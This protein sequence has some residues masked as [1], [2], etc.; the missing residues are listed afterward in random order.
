MK[1]LTV[2]EILKSQTTH[3]AIR[4]Q[5]TRVKK[6][7]IDLALTNHRWSDRH[8]KITPQ[9][10]QEAKTAEEAGASVNK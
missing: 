1:N 3:P 9:F 5:S 10:E 8:G 4:K 2:A 6:T 7:K